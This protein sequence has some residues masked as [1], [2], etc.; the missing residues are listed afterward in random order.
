MIKDDFIQRYIESI[1]PFRSPVIDI[2][3]SYNSS[4]KEAKQ[5]QNYRGEEE[6]K[7]DLRKKCLAFPHAK[8]CATKWLLLRQNSPQSFEPSVCPSSSM[9]SL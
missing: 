9:A 8:I 6:N 2:S 4:R 1:G 5:Q 3:S 7:S